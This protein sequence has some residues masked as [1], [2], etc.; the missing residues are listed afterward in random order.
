M[1]NFMNTLNLI[2]LIELLL[3]GF[4]MGGVLVSWLETTTFSALTA[5]AY[6]AWHQTMDNLFKRLMGVMAMLWLASMLLILSQITGKSTAAA[7]IIGALVCWFGFLIITLRIEVPINR[8]I[9]TWSLNAIPANWN[10]LRVRWRN[11]QGL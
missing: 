11:F 6:V 8:Q 1:E 2:W 10:D 4:F 9:E 3:S 5:E 7:L